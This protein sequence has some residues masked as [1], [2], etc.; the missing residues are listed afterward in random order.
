MEVIISKINEIFV[1][2][3]SLIMPLCIVNLFF[4]IQKNVLLEIQI[5][6]VV[7][8]RTNVM[9]IKVIVTMT[10]IVKVV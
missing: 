1:P 8:H 4:H 7:A 9:R 5:R 2:K 6:I 3:F 10:V